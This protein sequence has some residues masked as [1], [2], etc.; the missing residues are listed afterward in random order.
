MRKLPTCV[1]ENDALSVRV[2]PVGA[3]LQ[4]VVCGG[5][6]RMW[7]GDLRCGVVGLRCCSR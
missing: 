1:L 7:S 4:S 6:E 2:S 5:V 3:E